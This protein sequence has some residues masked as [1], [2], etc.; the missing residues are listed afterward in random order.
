MMKT[1]NGTE[2]QFFLTELKAVTA[3][4]KTQVATY[5]TAFSRFMWISIDGGTKTKT[6]ACSTTRASS[7][8]VVNYRQHH[9]KHELNI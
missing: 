5:E 2:T 9:Q 1:V 4:R 3:L 6:L 8:N 7:C